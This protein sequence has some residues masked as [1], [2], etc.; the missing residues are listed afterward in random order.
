MRVDYVHSEMVTIEVR[1]AI[2]EMKS[3]RQIRNRLLESFRHC[4][5]VSISTIE[6]VDQWV[7]TFTIKM[8][9]KEMKRHQEHI[10]NKVTLINKVKSLI[11]DNL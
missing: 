7:I 6:K 4:E 5:D 8:L 2:E 10:H 1:E 9:V 3:L 11:E